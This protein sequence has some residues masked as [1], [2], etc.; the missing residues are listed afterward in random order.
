[1][2]V[3]TSIYRGLKAGISLFNDLKEIG[4]GAVDWVVKTVTG[5]DSSTPKNVQGVANA[6]SSFDKNPISSQSN[7][8]IVNGSQSSN[9]TS[10]VNT[11]PITINTQAT[12]AEQISSAFADSLK[13]Q[14]SFAQSNYDDG[15]RA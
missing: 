4:G 7:S 1:L 9:K 15:V 11:G 3:I 2:H 10:N 14:M 5:N 13:K 12:N 8:S 6:I